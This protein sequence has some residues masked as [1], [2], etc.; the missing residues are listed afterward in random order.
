MLQQLKEKSGRVA[1]PSSSQEARECESGYRGTAV[2][3]ESPPLEPPPLELP[4]LEPPPLELPP[5]YPEDETDPPPPEDE[6]PDPDVL[7]VPASDDAV[8][9]RGSGSRWRTRV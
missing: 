2:R 1:R 9:A 6:D 5:L 3:P 8:V 4:P 7:L